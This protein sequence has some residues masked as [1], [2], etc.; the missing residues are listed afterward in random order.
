VAVAGI[1]RPERFFDAV[2]QQG[3]DVARVLTFGDH[4]WFT[5]RDLQSIRRAAQETKADVVMTTEK[6]AARLDP[7]VTGDL[8]WAYLP[9]R[10][11]V[12]PAQVFTDW[13]AERLVAAR[14]RLGVVAA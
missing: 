13:L 1:A 2:R 4:H 5:S 6:D 3:W 14:R 11:E 10:V 9:L 12:E 8:P 7:G